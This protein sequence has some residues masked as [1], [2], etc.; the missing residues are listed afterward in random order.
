MDIT[1]RHLQQ[2]KSLARLGSF[3][4]TAQ[5]LNISQPALSRSISLLESRLGVQLFDRSNREVVPTLFGEH[6]LQRGQPVLQ[7]MLMMERDLHLLQGMESGEL[8]IGSGPLPAEISLGKAV[9]RFNRNYPKVNVRIILDRTPNL[10]SRLR[11]REL[12]I[13][14]AD[15]RIIKDMSDLEITLLPQQQGHFCCR[16]GHPLTKKKQI[17]VKDIFSYPLAVMWFPRV[18]LSTLARTAGLQLNDVT[19][20]PCAVLQCD[21]LKVLFDIISDSD[22]TGLITRSLLN[23]TLQQQLVLLPLSVPELNTHYGLVTLARYSQ[24]PVVQ[25]FQRY[26]IE[27]EEQC[28]REKEWE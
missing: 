15:T 8:V 9:A 2:I 18:L 11:N 28:S 12:D 10:L 27:E 21:Y 6:L 4:K 7:E 19:D 3:A 13:F 14:V 22:A 5:A 23:P 24:P 16:Y 20:L 25:M 26:M 17:K 1:F